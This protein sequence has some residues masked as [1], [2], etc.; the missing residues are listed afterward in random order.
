MNRI[1]LIAIVWL[2]LVVDVQAA[3]WPTYRADSARSNYTPEQLPKGL[4]LR[5]TYQSPHAPTPAWP[6]RNRQQFD[7]AYQP[8]IAGGILYYGSSADCKVYA[9][10]AV[11]GKTRWTFFTDSPV[12][13]T[14]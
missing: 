2:L 14:L 13:I 5:W 12:W 9:L 10:D 11:T 8:V 7:R 4:M 6:T 1:I 3:D